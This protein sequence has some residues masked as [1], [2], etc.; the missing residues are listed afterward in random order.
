MNEPANIRLGISPLK[1]LVITP[2][3][4]PDHGPSAPIF[5]ALCED[6]H[7]L[8]YDVTVITT[9]P[10]YDRIVQA[11]HHAKGLIQEEYLNGVRVLRTYVFTV[12]KGALWGRLL[13]HASVNLFSTWASFRIRKPDIVLADAP[14]LWSGLPLLVKAVFPKVPFIYIVY[15]IYPDVLTRL[16]I[17]RNPHLV[18]LIERVEK[19]FYDR[20]SW[21]SVLSEG[22]KENL[23]SKGV[24]QDKIAVIPVCVDVEFIRPLP[25]ENELKKRWGLANKFV[26][27][28]AGNIGLSQG[29]E[30]VLHAANLLSLYPDIVFVLVGEGA[31]KPALQAKAEELGLSNVKF[32]PFQSPE[33]VPL[34]Y[35]LADIC[36][37]ALKRNIIVE[38]VPSKTYT[39]MASARPIVATVDRNTEVG[40]LLEKA[41]C[42]LCVEPE[43]PE[44]LASTILQL[45]KDDALRRDMGERGRE[46]VITYYPRQFA[47]KQYHTLIQGLTPGREE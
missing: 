4:A 34:V 16:G 30:T 17:L 31:T 20:S 47:A 24:P 1:I 15:D 7:G 35:S 29:L 2:H 22:F 18:R 25:H 10:H 5:T 9:F 39:I 11:N 6:L 27:L 28:Y 21:V 37:I 36:L 13:Y 41:E 19:F 33:D 44:A 12:P 42:G 38:S 43:N 23:V 46:Y 14:T 45:Y 26:V 32:F 3:Y 40:S 8:G